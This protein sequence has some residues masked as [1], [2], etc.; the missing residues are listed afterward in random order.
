[1]PLQFAKFLKKITVE[2]VVGRSSFQVE[3]AD[4]GK[5]SEEFIEKSAVVY[6]R[7]DFAKKN[8]FKEGDVVKLTRENR[9]VN[10]RVR[11]A[12]FAPKEG[13]FIPNSIYAS[14]LSDFDCFKRFKAS[15]EPADG[16]VTKPEEII[17]KMLK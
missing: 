9:S 4:K 1:M 11:L 15:L 14:Y 13:V 2:V 17:Q 7:E 5:F 16:G 10:L 8:G 3:S 6:M 12:D